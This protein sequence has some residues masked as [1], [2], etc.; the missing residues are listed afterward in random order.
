[1]TAMLKPSQTLAEFLIASPSRGHSS[2][3]YRPVIRD[4]APAILALAA[5]VADAFLQPVP[6]L[7]ASVA[8][9]IV[10]A[11]TGSIGPALT[12]GSTSLAFAA[13][14][15]GSNTSMTVTISNP[16]TADLVITSLIP[17]GDFAVATITEA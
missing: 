9:A 8:D 5:S 1:M 2:R 6:G 11:V 13:T 14:T 17:T 15:I 7:A 12:F 4:Y 3:V 16:G 10:Q